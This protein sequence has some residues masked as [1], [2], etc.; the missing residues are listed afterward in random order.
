M[1]GSTDGPAHAARLR[2]PTE[3]AFDATQRILYFS[4]HYNNRV[5][6]VRH[7]PWGGSTGLCLR[8]LEMFLDGDLFLLFNTRFVAFR[9]VLLMRL[10]NEFRR[11]LVVIDLQLVQWYLLG[12]HG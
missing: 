12:N 8:A 4:D 3:V 2:H 10:K 5:R 7:L 1:F 11:Q 9:R 6:Y